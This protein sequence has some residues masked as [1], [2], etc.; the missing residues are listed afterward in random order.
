MLADVDVRVPEPF[1]QNPVKVKG[2]KEG[3]TEQKR[4]KTRH[5]TTTRS[6]MH[7]KN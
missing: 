2:S 1:S 5:G 4:S 7:F 3:K 6:S